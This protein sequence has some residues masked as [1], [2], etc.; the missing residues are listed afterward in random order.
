M[1]LALVWLALALAH[2]RRWEIVI[3]RQAL[4]K[5]VDQHVELHPHIMHDLL[6]NSS[7]SFFPSSRLAYHCEYYYA[8]VIY[9]YAHAL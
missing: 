5:S 3:Y 7:M 1:A 2:V 8:R 4:G 6:V 9:Y